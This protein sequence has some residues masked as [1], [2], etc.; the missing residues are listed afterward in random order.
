MKNIKTNGGNDVN[1]DDTPI[2]PCPT[3]H[4]TLKA[5]SMISRY[6]E[7]LNHPIAHK[8]KALLGSFNRQLRLE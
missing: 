2:E 5:G 4:D 1:K 7:D 3:W 8:F 6:A